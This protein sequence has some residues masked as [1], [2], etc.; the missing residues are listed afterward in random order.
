MQQ[1]GRMEQAASFE[2]AKGFKD[3]DFEH[4]RVLSVSSKK[5][6]GKGSSEGDRKRKSLGR[7]GDPRG[8]W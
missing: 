2:D 3:G 7:E 5:E 1:A 4:S 8:K 6:W